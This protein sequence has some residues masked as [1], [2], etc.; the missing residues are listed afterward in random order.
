MA[1]TIILSH[2]YLRYSMNKEYSKGSYQGESYYLK[3]GHF[4]VFV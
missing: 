2:L 3:Y 1:L 4:K